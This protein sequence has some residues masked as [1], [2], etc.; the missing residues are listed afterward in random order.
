MARMWEALEDSSAEVREAV[1][2]AIPALAAAGVDMADVMPVITRLIKVP[3]TPCPVLESLLNAMV[4]V[5]RYADV[6]RD[7]DTLQSVLLLL[8]SCL[9]NADRMLKAT[10]HENII[11]LAAERG[12]SI[13]ELF[14]QFEKAIAIALVGK[15]SDELPIDCRVPIDCLAYLLNDGSS[16]RYLAA[17]GTQHNLEA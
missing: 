12:T 8:V 14:R 1:V 16:E 5:G 3:Q 9:S 11:K 17:G 2:K 4:W 7:G 6:S 10:A 15:L 13:G